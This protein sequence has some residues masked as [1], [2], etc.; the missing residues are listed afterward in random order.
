MSTSSRFAPIYGSSIIMV[1]LLSLYISQSIY[2]PHLPNLL[3]VEY[4]SYNVDLFFLT[5]LLRLVA[6]AYVKRRK[7]VRLIVCLSLCMLSFLC[8]FSIGT[9]SEYNIGSYEQ[10]SIAVILFGPSIWIL[11]QNLPRKSGG[12]FQE[13]LEE[14]LSRNKRVNAQVASRNSYFWNGSGSQKR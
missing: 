2:P 12:T 9:W 8:W 10:R 7:W 1:L 11:F 3:W 4:H 14:R 5:I 13:L 6:I